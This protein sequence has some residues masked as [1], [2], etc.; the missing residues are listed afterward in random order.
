MIAFERNNIARGSNC[1]TANKLAPAY[2]LLF[3]NT[4]FDVLVDSKVIN[5]LTP[6][7]CVLKVLLF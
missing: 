3:H 6:T 4:G 7:N 1:T 2:V 5:L